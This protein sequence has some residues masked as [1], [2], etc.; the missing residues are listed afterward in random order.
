M[1][2]DENG[3]KITHTRFEVKA[4]LDTKGIYLL[5]WVTLFIRR[6]KG[7]NERQTLL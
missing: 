6:N 7:N 3:L 1:R 4:Y 5:Q 2:L